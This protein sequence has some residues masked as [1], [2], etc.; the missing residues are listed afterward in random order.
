VF[1]VKHEGSGWEDLDP[2]QRQSLRAFGELLRAEAIPRGMVSS[3]DAER[4]HERHVLDSLRAVRWIPAD[5]ERVC[6]LGSGAGLPGI[7]VAIAEPAL[8]VTLSEARIQRVAFLELAVERLG[9]TNV[10]VRSGAAQE[11][12]RAH[13]DAC[14]ARGFADAAATWDIAEPLLAPRG[15]ALYWAGRSFRPEDAPL[16][17][18]VQVVTPPLES[19]GPIAIM[20]R[21]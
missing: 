10:V 11:L 6:D 20:T 4:L 19:G 15:V 9:L 17:V 12:P 18:R 3:S 13:F 21:Q 7:P 1:H 2:Q 5:A 16:G 14:L 8:E